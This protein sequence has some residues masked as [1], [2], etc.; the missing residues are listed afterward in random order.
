MILYPG[1]KIIWGRVRG[2]RE[3]FISYYTVQ[4]K[5]LYKNNDSI[6]LFD[7]PNTFVNPTYMFYI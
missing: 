3:Y 7:L 1:M 2:V 5:S 6:Y 4:I